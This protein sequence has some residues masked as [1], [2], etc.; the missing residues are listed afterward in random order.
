MT[1]SRMKPEAVLF[2]LDGTLVD[3]APDFFAVVN[4]LRKD[5]GKPELADEKIREQVSNGGS[6]LTRI[7]F[8]YPDQAGRDLATA[9]SV[10]IEHR[11]QLLDRYFDNIGTLSG[12]F[13][14]FETVINELEKQEIRWGIVTNKPRLYTDE[15]LKKLNIQCDVV[16]CPDDVS[17][18]KP[19]PEPLLK[20]A[21][22]LGLKAEQCWYVGDHIRDIQ[23]GK[24]AEMFTLAASFGYIEADDSAENWQA[25]AIIETPEK[26]LSFIKL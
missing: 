26:L 22:I 19:D 23:A 16:I 24:A 7:A 18:A 11:Q 4:G 15:L 3:T 20:A 10:F 21:E 2:D 14:G 8:D 25:D 6:A 9:S 17:K 12:Y 13:P 1:S 5:Q